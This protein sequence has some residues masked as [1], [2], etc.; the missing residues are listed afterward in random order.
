MALNT[1]LT[2]STGLSP[3]MQT[4]Y[5]RRLLENMKPKLVHM[6]YGQKRPIPKNGG[7]TIQF[8]KFTPFNALTTP[9]QEGIIP[10]GQTLNQTEIT[11]T[12][13]QYGGYVAV[14]DLLDLT[15]I[16]P[17][18][19]E[20]V[21]LLSDQ[22]A[23]TLDTLV[24]DVLHSGTNVQ[25]ANGK[26]ARNQIT[27]SDKLTLTEIRK[28]VRTL[29][30]NKARPFVRNGREFYVCIVGPDTTFD[31][32]SDQ[33]WQDVSKYADAE[34]IFNGEI[35]RMFGVVFVETPQA[36]IFAGQ[37]ASGA[38]VASTLIFGKDAYGLID[39]AGSGA[40]KTIIKPRGSA[41]TADPLDQ[42]S[43]I[44]WKVEAFTAKILQPLW[45]LRIEHG[46]SA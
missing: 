1:N 16:D 8:R 39:I 36:K 34:R 4:Y 45:I 22:A 28:A 25:Y 32:Q 23:L 37:G 27:S 10:D 21:E 3:T 38:D 15:A 41:G 11:A 30:K 12:V 33:L 17:I 2:T 43:T 42:I 29:K 13:E 5:D 24:R 26:T 35:G 40:V 19:D 6:E 18:I 9:L 20:S 31:L 14:S 46:F 44:G 7:K